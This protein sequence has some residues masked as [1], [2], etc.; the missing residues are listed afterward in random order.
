MKCFEKIS[1]MVTMV[2]HVHHAVATKLEDCYEWIS[3]DEKTHEYREQP[4]VMSTLHHQV[5]F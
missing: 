3:K 1:T 4:Q 5:K 2:T